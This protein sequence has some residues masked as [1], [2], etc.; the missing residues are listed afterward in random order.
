MFNKEKPEKLSDG[1]LHSQKLSEAIDEVENILTKDGESVVLAGLGNQVFNALWAKYR[2][3]TRSPRQGGTGELSLD[4]NGGNGDITVK[5]RRP[6]PAPAPP[7][8]DDDT[9]KHPW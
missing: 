7:E 8:P 9:E 5:N 3:N 1:Q 2:Q 4:F 6:K